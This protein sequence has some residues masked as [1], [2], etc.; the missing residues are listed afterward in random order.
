MNSNRIWE[1]IP[2][3]LAWGTLITLVILSWV[4]PL[5]VAI[6]IILFDLYWFL[7]TLY[8]FIHLRQSFKKLTIN[9]KQNWLTK[10]IEEKSGKWEN[11]YH[12]IIIPAMQEPYRVLHETLTGLKNANYPKDKLLIVL[13][14]ESRGGREDEENGKKL[15][16]EFQGVFGAYL[17]TMHPDGLEGEVRGKASNASWGAKEAEEKIIRSLQIPYKDVIV[18]N[19]DSDARPEKEYFGILTH[20]FLSVE[21]PLHTSFQ[22]TPFYTNNIYDVSTFARVLGFTGSFWQLIQQARPE[23]LTTFSGY[24]I[25]WQAL[26]DVNFWDRTVIAEDAR[27]FFQCLTHYNGNW[28]TVPIE[29]PITMNATTG[30]TTWES[31]KNLYKQQRRW[32][33]G[34]ENIPYVMKCFKEN[35][36]I[37]SYQKNFWRIKLISIFLAWATSSFIMFLFGWLPNIFG[38]EAFRATI[39]SHNLPALTSLIMN[40]S[41]I[42]IVSS[43]FL[44]VFFLPTPKFKF[45]IFRYALYCIE[46]VCVPILFLFFGGLPALD[47]ETRLMLGGKYKLGFWV[48]PKK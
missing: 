25:P 33:W 21:D 4:A 36:K 38:G 16:N 26:V 47:A 41:L 2:G 8:L 46:W 11:L 14:L 18:S 27:I 42:G 5:W 30:R 20:T 19:F 28:R 29:Y 32:A 3:V 10:L 15:E 13:A 37:K 43:A 12:L 35:K 39:A 44:G 45:K 34:V 9:R 24:S 48:T 31:I 23:Q 6:F 1:I 22:P 40:L 7:K 17:T